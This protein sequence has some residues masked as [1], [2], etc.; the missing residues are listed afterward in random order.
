MIAL[1]LDEPGR[2]TPDPESGARRVDIQ[3][4]RIRTKNPLRL[5]VEG[6]AHMEGLS[7]GLVH[8]RPPL[9]GCVRQI[10]L[11]CGF[12]SYGSEG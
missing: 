6:A 7:L 5:L 9:V 2:E 8:G 4:I 3:P 11:T 1:P 12:N 10:A